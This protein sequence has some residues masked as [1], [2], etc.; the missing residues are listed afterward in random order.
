MA[1]DRSAP[2][3]L[4]LDAVAGLPW[5]APEAA[6]LA[7]LARPS[8]A[9]PLL[10][11]DPA[12][13]ALLFRFD[14]PDS[15]PFP[16]SLLHDPAPLA[17]SLKRLADAPAGCASWDDPALRPVHEAGWI[18][19]R[20]AAGLAKRTRRADPLRAWCAAL[21][22]PVGWLAVGSLS[23][24]RLLDCWTD[25]GLSR[26]P[27]RIQERHWGASAAAITRRL[28]R[29]WQWPA[30]LADAVG[31]IELP[32]SAAS[33]LGGDASLVALLRLAARLANHVGHDPALLPRDEP[34]DADAAHL[35]LDLGSLDARELLEAEPLEV[36]AW[37]SPH[38]APLLPDVL[39]LAEE[40][41]RLLG[42]PSRFRMEREADDLQAALRDAARGEAERLREAKLS[43]LAEFAA[44]AGHEIN[45]PLTVISGQAQ[46]VLSHGEEWLAD[47][48]EGAARKALTTI[49]AQTRRVHAILRDLMLFA[50]P[51]PS[52]PA[53][54][55]LPTLMG[56]VA[57][58]LEE[59]ALSRNVRLE[60]KA[61]PERLAAWADA[62]QVRTAL[63]CLARNAVE[64]APAEGWARLSVD[65]TAGSVL[66]LLIEDSG[67]G[68][69]ADQRPHLFDPFFS[70]RSAGRGKG[71]GLPVAWRLARQQGGD[72]RLDAPRPGQPTRF[73]LTLPR[74]AVAEARHAA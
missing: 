60:V 43:A 46:Y 6:S 29:A 14:A 12:A 72:V 7:A 48:E 33:R 74:A 5:L 36:P 51:A 25:P 49:I 50:R 11:H 68:P 23:T 63:A 32:P 42:D 4:L 21:L 45:N 26:D 24:D 16:L 18:M 58:S 17:F 53:C 52:R 37:Q 1:V 22:A 70:G 30:W 69:S 27:S 39:G 54:F 57:A 65:G 41:R 9:W 13:L 15:L 28:A 64:A 44:G 66:E 67:P 59:L 19:A 62:E 73:V 34:L 56:E 71:L 3:G 31:R 8:G 2:A 55:D 40:N 38:E 10:R 20:L 61:R 35:G 47:D